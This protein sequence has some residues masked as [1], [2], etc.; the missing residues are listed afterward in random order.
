MAISI[1][2]SKSVAGLLTTFVDRVFGQQPA[3]VVDKRAQN[4][5]RKQM[6]IR[7][8]GVREGFQAMRARSEAMAQRVEE[9][10]KHRHPDEAVNSIDPV[11]PVETI[12]LS[13]TPTPRRADSAA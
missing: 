2:G 13:S 10:K 6:N 8:V 9:F 3:P 7:A 4:L 5:A 11:E 12:V 1:H